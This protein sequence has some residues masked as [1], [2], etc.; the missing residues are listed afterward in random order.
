M[1]SDEAKETAEKLQEKFTE[2]Y[3]EKDGWWSQQDKRML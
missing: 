3:E 1:N 2:L